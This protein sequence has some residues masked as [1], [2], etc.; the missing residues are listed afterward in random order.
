MKIGRFVTDTTGGRKRV[1]ATV[2]WEDCDRA[3][4]E[5]YF[6][7]DSRFAESLWCNP[8]AF[9]V[10]C[11]VPAFV[12]GETRVLVEEA[13]CPELRDGL[14][15]ALM[16]L[17]HWFYPP[18]RNLP[19]IEAKAQT[20]V[21]QRTT[22]GRAGLLFSG[23]IDSLSVLRWNR[24]HV[25]AGHP[26]S[27]KDG[28]L[29]FGLQGEDAQMCRDIE[30]QLSVIAEDAGI[31]L[32]PIT[33]NL[34]QSLGRGVEWA[35]NWQGSVLAAAPHTLA[36]RLTEASISSGRY[37]QNL[38]PFGTHPVLDPNYSSRDLRIRHEGIT[39]SRFA[40]TKL[41]VEWDTALQNL[42]VCNTI[43]FGKKTEQGLLNC[44]KCEKC[45]RTMLAL[46]AVGA[47]ERTRAFAV[48]DVSAESLRELCRQGVGN[49]AVFYDELVPLLQ[50][51]GRKDLVRAVKEVAKCSRKYKMMEMWKGKAKDLDRI[52]LGARLTRLRRMM[53]PGTSVPS[54]GM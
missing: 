51:K 14:M 1:S 13:I 19:T 24:L 29:L 15:T 16:W 39:L 2:T 48:S 23:G 10:G 46:V 34:V 17:R 21:P 30:A 53:H 31:A 22:V 54:Q 12:L 44:G 45:I 38:V 26:A 5:I 20:F 43:P 25:P 36:G 33:T 8:H 18:D 32:V 4:C 6:E 3:P 28:V 9:V 7:T 40:K 27:F 52:Y 41:L 35:T 50:G 11:I 37:I 49:V 42:R 47:L